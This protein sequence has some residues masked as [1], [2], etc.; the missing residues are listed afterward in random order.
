MQGPMGMD[1][2]PTE[3][4]RRVFKECNHESFWYRC[5]F[6][7]CPQRGARM[8]LNLK[9]LSCFIITLMVH[10]FVFCISNQMNVIHMHRCYIIMVFPPLPISSCCHSQQSVWLSLRS[11]LPEVKPYDFF[12]N[13]FHLNEI[14]KL[15]WRYT[16]L[17]ISNVIELQQYSN[18]LK[19]VRN[20][21]AT[22][23]NLSEGTLVGSPRFGSL[24]KVACKLMKTLHYIVTKLYYGS[25]TCIF[26]IS[27]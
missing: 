8:H 22:I 17:L 1:Y 26:S 23:L 11:Y 5:K 19:Q 16:I 10:S 3:E 6:I 14:G 15:T 2:V 25:V 18:I 13:I 24:P 20:N 7:W 4:E 21:H 12:F 27:L 9:S